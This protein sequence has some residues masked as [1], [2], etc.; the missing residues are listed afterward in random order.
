MRII[1]LLFL[2]NFACPGTQAQ[3]KYS[4]S[5]DLTSISGDRV[6]V[7]IVPPHITDK[8][9][10]YIMPA[11]IPGSYFRK[12]F[13]RF[14][15]DMIVVTKN[16]NFLDI[17]KEGENVFA[18][19][20]KGEEEIAKIEYFIS[21]SWDMEKPNPSMSDE[22]FNYVF[23]PGG[24]NIQSG[25]NFV[26]NHYGYFGYIDGHKDLPYE[27]IIQKPA[28]MYGSTTL[29][30]KKGTATKDFFTAE[31]YTKLVDNPILYC[32][33]D[34]TSFTVDSTHISISV[35]SENGIVK[36]KALTYY[37]M[38]L[39][40]AVRDDLGKLPVKQYSFIMYF[41]SPEN[42]S[43]TKYGGFGAMEHNYCSFYFL[44]EIARADSLDGIIKQFVPHN[45]MHILTPL[46]IHSDKFDEFDFKHVPQSAHLWMYEG[47]TEYLSNVIQ[48]KD[49]L[50]TEEEFMDIFREKMDRANTY[51]NVSLMDMSRDLN[52]KINRD[53]FMNVF[54][55][56]AVLALMMD[57]RLNELSNGKIGLK[58]VLLKLSQKYGSN[59]SFK[60][61][62]LFEEIIKLTYP[63]MRSFFDDYLIAN[64]PVP[65]KD[66]FNKLG[67]NYYPTLIDTVWSFG[68]FTM[69]VDQAHDELVVLKVEP[70][71][72]FGLEKGDFL[73][74]VDDAPMNLYTFEII[75]DPIYKA[76]N[77]HKV[78]LGYRRGTEKF[79]VE[80]TPVG[81][82][83]KK[84]N[85]ITSNDVASDEQLILRD[86]VFG[87]TP[88]KR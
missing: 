86:K 62:S 75:M 74:S 50:M 1:L 6:K 26:I 51:P 44:P 39:A 15:S 16:G 69:A 24:T 61:D 67:M 83:E 58:D 71:N 34:T 88:Q 8:E 19:R 82:A 13:G 73:L 79:R 36:S 27:L 40:S 76:K 14:V 72:L 5:L 54:D 77:G 47:V 84:T 4:I 2:I 87:Y 29:P 60:D 85:V 38:M 80:A 23:Q 59:K 10:R 70:G 46:N 17:K 66:Y 68:K 49:S 56:G 9:I 11:F 7:S 30:R 25:K 65:Y 52:K 64:K 20:N 32:V 57:V 45:F 31:N 55:K 53:A 35:Y 63:E 78:T 43:M 42:Q 81:L 3:G 41:A 22:E 18:I 12:D 48:L 28:S 21:D 33:P 37:L